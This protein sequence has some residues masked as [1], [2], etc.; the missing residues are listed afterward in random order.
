MQCCFPAHVR[1]LL[2][3]GVEFVLSIN[4]LDREQIKRTRWLARYQNQAMDT[5][6]NHQRILDKHNID[7]FYHTTHIENLFSIFNSG[8][9]SRARAQICRP[10]DTS[11]P[12]EWVCP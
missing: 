2:R 5:R 7:W 10:T 4:F 6:A 1:V 11:D 12:V 9:H 8:L 3:S